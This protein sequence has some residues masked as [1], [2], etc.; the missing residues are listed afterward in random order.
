MG[1][2]THVFRV[3]GRFRMMNCHRDLGETEWRMEKVCMEVG[4]EMKTDWNGDSPMPY[5]DWRPNHGGIGL[6]AAKQVSCW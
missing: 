5:I 2:R 1:T 4:T 6:D 3:F